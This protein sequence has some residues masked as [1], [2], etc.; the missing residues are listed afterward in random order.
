S[1]P[2][3]VA[4]LVVVR[5]SALPHTPMTLAAF[6]AS[7][8]GAWLINFFTMALIGSLAFFLESSTAV[9][10]VWLVAFMLL[11]GYLVPIELFPGWLRAA[12][13]ALPFR[14]T[15]G[16]PVELAIGLLDRATIV[17]EL[18]IQLAYVVVMG[19]AAVLAFRAGTRRFEAYGG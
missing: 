19:A 4:A 16:F 5:G 12:A 15:I 11:S 6:A 9:F 1:A 2:I 10:D 14:F 3:A 7:L 13:D 8:V 17:R 18:G